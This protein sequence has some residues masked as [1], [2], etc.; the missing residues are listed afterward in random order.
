MSG[1]DDIACEMGFIV[2]FI[3]VHLCHSNYIKFWKRVRNWFNNAI[4]QAEVT[5][6]TWSVLTGAVEEFL[7]E[8][9]FN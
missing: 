4:Q 2:P 6:K 8:Q 1:Q 9:F 3:C 7:M 5:W